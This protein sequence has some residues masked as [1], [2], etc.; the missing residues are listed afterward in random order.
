MVPAVS[1]VVPV[2]DGARYIRSCLDFM[3]SQTFQDFELIFVIGKTH[4]DDTIEL[5]DR[6]QAEEGSFKVVHQSED[7]GLGENR[8]SGVRAATADLIWFCDVDDAP[9]AYFLEDMVRI[10]REHDADMVCCN[11]INTTP[12]GLIKEDLSRKYH[13]KVMDRD[14]A[15]QS[16]FNEEF[17]VASWS[18]LFKK[19]VIEDIGFIDKFCAEDIVHTFSVIL[20]CDKVCIYDRPL[21]AYR[22][23]EGSICSSNPDVRAVDEIKA[24]RIVE[25]IYS[26]TKYS[27]DAKAHCMLMRMRSTGH[28]SKKTFM[29]Y[30]EETG[31]DDVTGP[32]AK[33]LEGRLYRNLPA[34]YYFAITFFVKYI[35][36][37]DGS[38]GM[39][40][41][42]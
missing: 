18:K 9:S 33:S 19:S 34:L 11:F 31:H 15:V 42:F 3:K 38:K 12:S 5:I 27:E 6:L 37:R 39:R 7:T 24:Y 1:V 36:K 41:R 28:M 23:N 26:D 8:N 20:K 4:A 16:R 13:V 2:K 29:N 32:L 22:Q 14:E 25:E 30:F 40:K 17:P 21:Y 35:Y 10:Q